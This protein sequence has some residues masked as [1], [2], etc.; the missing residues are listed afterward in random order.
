MANVAPRCVDCGIEIKARPRRGRCYRCYMVVLADP[1]NRVRHPVRGLD[2]RARFAMHVD[3]SGGPDACWPWTLPVMDHGYAQFYIGPGK[4]E[5]A[6]RL[7]AAWAAGLDEPPKGKHVDH[8]CH[9]PETCPNAGA[10][11]LHRRCCNPKHLAFTT[12]KENNARSGSPS[13]RNAVKTHCPQKHPYSPENTRYDKKGRR[14]C[15]TCQKAAYRRWYES[16]GAAALA[17]DDRM[18]LCPGCGKEKRARQF[19]R[20]ICGA[21]NQRVRRADEAASA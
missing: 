10:A 1:T 20:G 8:L 6:H 4:R 14:T 19:R 5:L 17:D 7:A 15:I 16:L 12:P 13:A 2:V 11:C 3:T 21:C 9:D 18:H